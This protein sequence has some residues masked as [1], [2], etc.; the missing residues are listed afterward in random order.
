MDKKFYY[1]TPALVAM[2][3][4]GTTLVS[5][6]VNAEQTTN[7]DNKNII[8]QHNNASQ[9]QGEQKELKNQSLSVSGS[10]AYKD[11][12]IIDEPIKN[13][14]TTKSNDSTLDLAS[15]ENAQDTELN[16]TQDTS[17]VANS[18]E[19]ASK[20]VADQDSNKD[21]ENNTT[22]DTSN[23]VDSVDTTSN[24]VADQDSNK[25]VENSTTENTS[26]VTDSE[27]APTNNVAEQDG[28]K[29]V[30]NN[31]TEDASNVVDS[32]D[33]TSNNIADSEDTASN[34]VAEQDDNKDVE[35]NSTEDTSD[36]TDSVDTTSNNVAEQD[37]NK[38]VE[39]NST[40]DTSNA[41]DSEDTPTNNVADQ[42]DNKDVQNN[43]TE[44]TS[45]V[46]DSVDTASNNVTEQDDNKDV[47]NS[48]TEDT[49]NV[50]NSEEPASNNVA[51]QDGNKDVEN[52][53][54]EDT[55][56]VADSEDTTTNNVA[57]KDDN[58]NVENNTTEDTSNVADSEDTTSN[59]VADQ[60]DNKD[61][62]HNSTEDTSNVTDSEDTPTN[63]VADKDDNKNVENNTTEDTSNVADS[64]DTTTNNV[65]DQ[66]S[67]KDVKNNATEDTSNVTD[68]EDTTSNNVA[69]QDDNKD[70]ENNTTED[71]SNV[72]DSEEP[73]SKNVADQDGNKNVELETTNEKPQV[74]T[75]AF[76]SVSGAPTF[77]RAAATTRTYNPTV[78]SRTNSQIRSNNYA[79]PRYVEDFSSH[80]PKIPYRHGVGKPEGIIAHETANPN[81]T[82][83]GEIAY[84]KNNYQSAF[85]HAF[86][87]D[88]NIIE[89]APTDYLAWGAG[90]V[91]NQRF[92]HV[93]LV[94]V[95]GGDRFARSINNYADYIATNLAYYGLPL[96]S[97]ENDGT[98]TL[99]S[100]DAVSRYL[101]GTDHSDPYGW[102]AENNYTFNELIDLVREKYSYK[103]GHL[104]A[105]SKP[106]V[107]N[108]KP[109]TPTKPVVSK[110][111][112]TKPVVSQP[113]PTKP[114]VTKPTKPVSSPAKTVAVNYKGTVNPNI[115]GVYSSVYDST[116]KSAANKAGK[117]FN[118]GKQSTYN[119]Q[120]FYLLQ[121]SNG[122]PLG[123]VKSSDVQLQTSAKPA[124]SNTVKPKPVAKP[125]A[126]NTVKP[127]PVAKP[128]A[129][130][131]VKPKPVAKPAASNTVKPKPVAKPAASNTVKPKPVAK[132]A[133]S[134]T[135]KP[136]PVATKPVSSPAKT[137]VVK[138][139]GT[140]NP[141]ISGVYSSVY[142]TTTKSATN[143]AGKTFNIGK[144]ST[145]NNQVFYLLQDSNGTPLGW[146]KSNDIR[147]QNTAKPAASNTVK[148]KPVA[149]PAA[150][151]TVK[152]KPVAKSAVS[153]TVKP[154]P[155]A[156]PAASNTVKP[157][158]VA[159]SAV[160]NT[161][162]PKPVA[163]TTASNSV[164]KTVRVNYVGKVNQNIS[165]VYTS[166][167]DQKTVPALNKA[168]K[169]FKIGKQSTYNNQTFYL[170]QDNNA[171]PLGWV[172]ARDVQLQTTKAQPK[173]VKQATPAQPKKT[174]AIKYSAVNNQPIP[175]KENYTNYLIFDNTGYFY[176]QP[177][178]SKNTLLGSLQNYQYAYFKVISSQQI[179]NELW[180]KGILN[181]KTV[182]INS[183]YLQ[184]AT[185]A[186][187]IST[188]PY[189]LD[190]AV[191]IQ[192]ALR[193]GSEPKKVLPSGVRNATRAE[194]KDAMDT[195]KYVNDPVQKYQ[196]LDL[197]KSQGISVSKLN[198]L[199]RG[200]G[201]L[202][203]QGEAF[204]QAAKAVGVNEIYLISHALL[205]TGNGTSQL[206]NGGAIDKNGKVDLNPQ[207]KYYNMF[208]VGAIDNNALYGGIK[209][210]QQ[211]GWNT[212]EKAILGGAQFISNNYIKA[213]Q[214][215]LYKMRFNPQNPGVHQYAT[216]VDFAKSNARRI[217]DFYQQIQTDGQYYDV[218]QYKS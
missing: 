24:N 207:T 119:N 202:E 44:D 194:V 218:D 195:T 70:V 127:K 162:K 121:D 78:S 160:S 214:N 46:A 120:V 25:D 97:A 139:K 101:G 33:T 181:G 22:E 107:S 118:I 99:W 182:W 6:Q 42:D 208:D 166:V 43:T 203:N 41:V 150:S 144:Q 185:E 54:T 21:V 12:S 147:L 27:D 141:N 125:A 135:V 111:K 116:T 72:A 8:E 216:G 122:T 31:T 66:E 34:N 23:T 200:K 180:Y 68:S 143:K 13:E 15:T 211:A 86:V 59:K 39:N 206:A 177:H 79:V 76:R 11:P 94:R 71:T 164:A 2:T 32:E 130:N 193:N 215:T 110:P 3:L 89:V 108:P 62:E 213:G 51:E 187:N 52:N 28:N 16:A 102:F 179:E 9:I 103:T 189:T 170:L 14:D 53:T 17:N 30:E 93:E 165:G 190:E 45:N 4:A 183:K 186:T 115:S 7:N 64:E 171:I 36:V 199:L 167:Y 142:D 132:P 73:A 92:I 109:A 84:M 61:V 198:D 117:T 172:N 38:D 77:R 157:K 173:A 113:K 82:I 90:G 123:W 126:S 184:L 85:V 57:D 48:T 217:S 104:T 114:V 106:V 112:P 81:S 149:K 19:P 133:A 10:K 138:Y 1:K 60:D 197:N 129:S 137:V 49:S 176:S 100:H 35:H 55:S 67:N 131:T 58:K 26:N 124:T 212:P 163:K 134:N 159:K 196:F 158:P 145:Y 168:G 20:N 205:E 154:K 128:A 169:T 87:D 98:G 175:L 37:N 191:N 40:E 174:N 75:F 63:N 146:V 74:S 69:D 50:A 96:D 210:A 156:K 29:D 201:I 136:K 152:P 161:V 151:N 47:E 83:Q 140:V 88:K 105:P 209:Y 65:A 56:N 5:H 204:S 91:A 148:P 95:Y 18:E 155:V 192:M 80:I 153:N 178:V 188:S